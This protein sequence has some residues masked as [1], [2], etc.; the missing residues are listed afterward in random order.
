METGVVFRLAGILIASV[1]YAVLITL[2]SRSESVRLLEK[3]GDGQNYF[4]NY[5]PAALSPILYAIAPGL[6]LFVL[7]AWLFQSSNSI[8]YIPAIG[9]IA[10]GCV[11]LFPYWYT[12]GK[13][14]HW[15]TLPTWLWLLV[16]NAWRL[17][18]SFFLLVTII[19]TYGKTDL[20]SYVFVGGASL[21]IM[22]R[23]LLKGPRP[24]Q[25]PST[26]TAEL[27]RVQSIFK[28][29]RFATL[30]WAAARITV[31]VIT[32]AWFLWYLAQPEAF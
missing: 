10:A 6:G 15:N 7:L 12:K 19:Y 1:V 28:P 22:A 9:S 29:L 17:A 13:Q 23:L 20:L 31:L 3:T 27:V 11:M 5:V 24:I 14:V 4:V 26:N 8:W 21:V 32:V 16:S 2:H 18:L 30:V 25:D